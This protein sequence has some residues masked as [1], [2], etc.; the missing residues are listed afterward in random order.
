M[1]QCPYCGKNIEENARF[2][3]YCMGS[4]DEKETI[5][6]PKNRR[7]VYVIAAVIVAVLIL[8]LSCC[9]GV[10][11]LQSESGETHQ[12]QSETTLGDTSA[13]PTGD[14]VPW[15]SEIKQTDAAVT[16]PSTAPTEPQQPAQTEPTEA[17]TIAPPAQSEPC[18]HQ[19]QVTQT[20]EPSCTSEGSN[21]YT[22]SRCGHSYQ[23]TV[24]ATGHSYKD[25]TCSGCGQA[26][27]RAPRWIYEYREPR[28]GDQL[29][30]GNWNAETDIVITGIRQIAEDG[31]YE[32]PSYIGEKRV[33]GILPLAFSDTDARSVTLGEHVF[34]VAQDAFSGCSRIAKLYV[35][36]DALYISRSAFI[37]AF[38]RDVTLQI[39]CSAGCTVKDVL[40]GEVPLKDIVKVYGGEFHEWNG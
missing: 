12:S 15:P 37:P 33:V 24:A 23:D 31:V 14:P 3:L 35:R 39:Y 38:R 32:I 7:V 30:Y 29:T 2:C 11:L 27:P 25:D 18:L 13:D 28:A 40:K 22:C 21:T 34:Y 6:Q 20:R 10:A 19:Y 17:P 8:G 26:D 5:P 36:G 1:R 9:A 4:L 16:Q